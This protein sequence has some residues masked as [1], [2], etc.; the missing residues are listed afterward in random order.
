MVTQVNYHL[1]YKVLSGPFLVS[2]TGDVWDG[3]N[4]KLKCPNHTLMRFMI[5]VG[6]LLNELALK[7]DGA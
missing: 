1:K 6:S 4:V 3:P 7:M 2:R 5:G